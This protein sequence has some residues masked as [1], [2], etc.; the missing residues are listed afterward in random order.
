MKKVSIL[1]PENAVLQ[2]IADPRYLFESVN[3]FLRMDGRDPLFTVQL[4]GVSEEVRL[5][6]GAF[7][8]R[9]DCRLDAAAGADLVVIPALSGNLEEAVE[10]NAPL[11]AF[12]RREYARGAEVASLC[13]GAFLL[14]ATGLLDEK[15]CSTHWGFQDQFR[16]LYPRVHLL[17]GSIVTEQDRLYT[18]GGA[19]SYWNLLLHLIEKYVDRATAIRAAKYFAIDIDRDSQAAFSIF[20]GHKTHDDEVVRHAQSYIERH[21]A[22]RIGVDELADRACLSRRTFERRFR[23]A[24]HHSVLQYISRVKMEFA[25]RSLESSQKTIGEVMGEVGY[26]D[27]SSF[28]ATFKSVTGL[29]PAA[30][31]RKYNRQ[32]STVN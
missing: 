20:Q 12:V 23:A 29:T 5:G 7:T 1:V 26:E 25:K 21:V 6:G 32:R 14:A 11:L 10:R 3:D 4:V 24:T 30:Y 18:S 16:Q 28:R 19:H 2:A 13:L 9:T 8:V 31:R 27:T 17:N 22:D 15:Q